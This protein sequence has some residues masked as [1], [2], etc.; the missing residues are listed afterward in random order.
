M[1]L[2]SIVEIQPD[3]KAA[4][5]RKGGNIMFNRKLKKEIKKLKENN[6]ELKQGII[7]YDDLKTNNAKLKEDRCK[8][9]DETETLKQKIRE[10]TEAD[11]VFICLKTILK[12]T[13]GE[14]KENVKQDMLSIA[15]LQRDLAAQQQAPSSMLMGIRGAL[16][17][18]LGR[19]IR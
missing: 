8:I 15:A 13:K 7:G 19:F 3:T 2:P 12:L 9:L 6:R 5:S 14:E 4:V 18:E 16:T 11:I 10:Q 17:S 1:L